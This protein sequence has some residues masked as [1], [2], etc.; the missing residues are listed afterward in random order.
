MFSLWFFVAC[1]SLV[2]FQTPVAASPI[3]HDVPHFF[4]RSP[5]TRHNLTA[6][7]VQSELGPLLSQGTLIFGSSSPLYANATWR[8]VE[9]AKPNIQVVVQPAQES[10]IAKIIKYC[11]ANSIE[12]LARNRGHGAS[13]SLNVFKGLEIELSSLQGMIIKE[14]EGIAILQAGSYA[15]P[16][17][18]ALWDRGYVTSTGSAYCVG[19]MG[20]ALGGGH[21]RLEGEYGLVADGLVHLNVVLADGSEVGVNS[22]SHQDLFYAMKGAGH[23]F[24]IVASYEVKIHPVGYNTWHYHNYTWTGD[25]LESVFEQLNILHTLDNGTTPVLMSYAGGTF[26]IDP[27][28]STTEAI[29]AFTFAYHGPAEDAEALLAPFNAIGAVHEEKGDVS[30]PELAV[31]EGTQEGGP[32]CQDAPFIVATN[33][34]VS[35]NITTTRQLYDQFNDYVAKYPGIGD[36]VNIVHEG[37][38]TKAVHAVPSDSTAYPHRVSNHLVVFLGAVLDDSLEAPMRT[39]AKEAWELWTAGKPS[40]K[41]DIYVNYASG[42]SYESI[43]S[44]YG[45][46]PWRLEKLRGLKAKYD[47]NNRFR[48]FVPIV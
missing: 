13:T 38:S 47:P 42:A 48:Y 20:P 43:E 27:S 30:Y 12:F 14:D 34:I 8:Y 19:L 29:I 11:N 7:T 24:G 44:I 10:D 32:Q 3:H 40:R 5:T 1:Y 18:N 26:S 9:F 45:Y 16:V 21:G 25:K 46:E 22:T 15:G 41:P 28:I 39:W 23:N 2:F 4:Q 6:S 37:Y 17:I 33:L 31:V 35:Y 36:G